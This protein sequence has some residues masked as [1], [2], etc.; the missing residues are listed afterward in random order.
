M[1][2]TVLTSLSV[3][4][5]SFLPTMELKMQYRRKRVLRSLT[6]TCDD[7]FTL[8]VCLCDSPDSVF[9]VFNLFF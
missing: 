3:V 8:H 4:E 2:E 7:M 6:G 9:N 1:P 5:T